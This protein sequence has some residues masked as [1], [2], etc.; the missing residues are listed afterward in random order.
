MIVYIISWMICK[1]KYKFKSINGELFYIDQ[2]KF[3]TNREFIVTN[4]ERKPTDK[5][6]MFL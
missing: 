5:N 3:L 1:L 6:K 4:R 2:E